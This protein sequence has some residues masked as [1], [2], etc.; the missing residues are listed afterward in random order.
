MDD[1]G[2]VEVCADVTNTGSRR[3]KQVV[4]LYVSDKNGTFGRPVK[5]LKGFAKV[6][7]EPG[8]TRTVSFTLTPRD[9]SYYD[10]TLGD[11]Y[12]PSGRYAILAGDA[13][14]H[15]EAEAELQFTTEKLL[16]LEIA[17]DTTFGELMADPRTA[18]ALEQ[19]S[20]MMSMDSHMET[21]GEGLGA[22][23]DEMMQAM[24]MYMPLK[25]LP[26]FTPIT[27]EQVAGLMEMLRQAV[28][29]DGSL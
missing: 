20:G 29:R 19:M 8:E 11:W 14:D 26:S 21:D 3:G 2:T 6:E 15:I 7:V 13:S 24:M 1:H 18:K 17:G 10:E 27:D 4:Q 16:P 28:N 5:E 12:A 22:G 25:S 23:Q 9:L